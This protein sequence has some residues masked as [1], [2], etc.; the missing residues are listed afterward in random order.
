M[1]IHTVKSGETLYGIAR[2]Y[3]TSAVKIAENNGLSDPDKIA[4]GQKLI[5][6]T[7]TRTY[8]VRGGDTLDSISRR[9]SVGKRT[10]LQNNPYLYGRDKTY[11]EQVLALKYDLPSHGGAV[12]NG[13]AG[14]GVSEERLTAIMPYINYLTV[15]AYKAE[16]GRIIRFFDDTAAVKITKNSGRIPIMRVYDTRSLAEI[17]EDENYINNLVYTAIGRGY[18]GITLGAYRAQSEDGWCE[19]LFELKK[20]MIECGLFLY[21]EIDGNANE[22]FPDEVADAHVFCYEKCHLENIP[23]FEDGEG[24]AYTEFAKKGD[25]T[26][27]YMDFSPFAYAD[28]E[29]MTEREAEAIAYRAGREIAYDSDKMICH[30]CYKKFSPQRTRE[31]TVAFDSPENKK[32]KLDLAGELGYMGISFDV[33]RASN[34]LI[35]MLATSFSVGMD[36]L[37]SSAEM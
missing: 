16:N 15:A 29:A 19:F 25:P 37:S 10:I 35:M 22:Y 17:C 12:V 21:T 31:V 6:L 1:Y 7:P 18:A 34:Q 13:Y 36:Y 14:R 2:A 9:F 24:R 30:F 20:R 27:A 4:V 26:R 28:G 23:S 33:L 11:P 32:A 3:G 5:I 8:T